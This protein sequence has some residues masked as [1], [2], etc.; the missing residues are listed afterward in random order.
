MPVQ[1]RL[2]GYIANVLERNDELIEFVYLDNRDRFSTMDSDIERI[3]FTV[4]NLEECLLTIAEEMFESPPEGYSGRFYYAAVLFV[5]CIK[6]DDFCR[7]KKDYKT[8]L[9]TDALVNVLTRIDFELPAPDF[10][11]R[12]VLYR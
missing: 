8:D 1:E 12:N 5:Y 4:D 11:I 10:T 9:L 7:R 3:K 6:I 2:R